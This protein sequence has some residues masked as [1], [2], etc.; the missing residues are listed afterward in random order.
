MTSRRGFFLPKIDIGYSEKGTDVAWHVNA[1]GTRVYLARTG[2]KLID[3]LD[4]QAADSHF[5]VRRIACALLLARLGLFQAEGTGR[6]FMRNI[7]GDLS[8]TTE[9]DWPDPKPDTGDPKAIARFHDWFAALTNHT[10]LRR[11]AEDAHLALTHPHEALV[12]VYRGLEWL[13]VGLGI[14]W[15]DLVP[16]IPG[17][18]ARQLKDL[19]KQANVDTGVRHATRDGTKIRADIYVSGT[20]VC[21]LIDAINS[22]RAT[23]EPGFTKMTAKEVGESVGL[24]VTGT[25]YE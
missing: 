7:Q 14:S 24:S 1:G 15:D 18:I 23:L 8:W 25:P 17:C 9:L 2:S 22:A 3:D 20:W 6:V 10:V 19:K 16:M 4:E 13:V 5:M 12:Y 21:A 11:A